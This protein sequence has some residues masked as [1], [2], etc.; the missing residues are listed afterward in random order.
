M[1]KRRKIMV[2]CPEC[3]KEAPFVIWDSINTTIHPEMKAAVRDGSAFCFKCPQCGGKAYVDFETL[4]H[5]MEDRI[6]VFYVDED[7]ADNTCK[8][9]TNHME[10][11]SPNNLKMQGYLMRVVISQNDLLEKLAIFD[12]GLD[13]RIIEIAK[14]L[15]LATVKH[16]FPDMEGN[17]A[18]FN[19][20]GDMNEII[21]TS[22]SGRQCSSELKDSIYECLVQDYGERLGEIRG[23]YPIINRSWAEG[24]L[25]LEK[26]WDEVATA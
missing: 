9:F 2:T 19:R 5:Q 23:S 17:T 25:E 20:E 12:A 14:L 10:D 16:N 21:V 22:N 26:G 3:G 11:Q 18:F 15:V 4:Y 1:S 7:E 13:D 6:M 8:L 24:F